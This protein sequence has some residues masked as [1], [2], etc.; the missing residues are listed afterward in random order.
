MKMGGAEKSASPSLYLHSVILCVVE[1]G[2]LIAI[3]LLLIGLTCSALGQA[4]D[5]AGQMARFQEF[6]CA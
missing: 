5:R 1:V 3:R 4:P 6:D 2:N